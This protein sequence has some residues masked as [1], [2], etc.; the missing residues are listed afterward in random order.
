[1]LISSA[2]RA[3]PARYSICSFY[4]S[5]TAYSSGSIRSCKPTADTWVDASCGHRKKMLE[6]LQWTECSRLAYR[7]VTVLS[8]GLSRSCSTK[9]RYWYSRYLL[10]SE[11]MNTSTVSNF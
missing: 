10:V 4:A 7:A 5:P 3:A 6:N 1:M 11:L 8:L 9:L 2:G